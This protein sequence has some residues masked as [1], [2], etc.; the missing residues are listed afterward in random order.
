MADHP[1]YI[2]LKGICKSFGP[3]VANHNINLSV[4]KGEIHALLGENGSGKSTLMNMLSG[5]YS[6]DAGEIYLD[7]KAVSFSEPAESIKAGIGMVHQH[8]KLVDVLSAKENIVA[9]KEKA[10]FFIK[11]KQ[12][13]EEIRAIEE[14]YGLIV[15]PDKKVYNMSVSEKQTVEILKVLY[16]GAN[17]LILDEPTAVLT[18]QEITKLFDI[19]R[20]MKKEGCS[21]IIITHK[22]NEVMEISDRVT[23]LRKGETIGTVNTKDTDPRQLTEMMVGRAVNLDIERTPVD[24]ANQKPLLELKDVTAKNGEGMEVLKHVSFTLKTGEILG[25]AGIAGSGQ[26][27]LCELIA[28]LYKAQDGDVVFK[29][30]SILGMTPAKIIQKG[31]SMSFIPEDRLG[32]GLV[33]GMD[34]VDNVLLKTFHEGKSPFVDRKAG[35]ERAEKIVER[36]QIDTPSVNHI[37]KKLSGGNI[38]KVLLGREIDMNP[39]LIITA[40]PVRGLDI[41]ASYN[42]YDILNQQKAKGG[43]ILFIGE[44]LDVLLGLCDRLMVIHDGEIMGIVD[45]KT[46]TK[47]DV[48]LL[49]LGHTPEEGKAC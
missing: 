23:V 13:T 16:R 24:E 44:D 18:P 25:V 46:V 2:E 7:G 4:E 10:G 27:E 29:G 5:I 30:E 40:Y 39:H 15:D 22:M 9:G 42:I 20:N 17:I 14:K 35:R 32:M 12:L 38:Q 34:I 36:F 26:K 1:A 21:I 41:G 3:V 45:P 8:F 37:V 6:P 43:G 49:M 19:L 28:G 11:Q 48:G 47:E 33:A 31:I